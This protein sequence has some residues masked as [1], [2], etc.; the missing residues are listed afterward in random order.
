V[1]DHT[2]NSGT[3]TTTPDAEST[4]GA[5]SAITPYGGMS[6]KDVAHVLAFPPFNRICADLDSAKEESFRSFGKPVS[7]YGIL[8]T[9]ARL[10]VFRAGQFVVRRDDYG[11]SA[12]IVLEGEL[13]VVLNPLLPPAVLGRGESKLPKWGKLF[14]DALRNVLTPRSPDVQQLK[15][16]PMHSLQQGEG[17]SPLLLDTVRDESEYDT[18]TLGPGAIVGEMSAIYRTPRS[19]SVVADQECQVLEIRWQGL[20]DLMDGDTELAKEIDRLYRER[21]L[22]H[23]ISR[24]PIF[25]HIPPEATDQIMYSTFGKYD[26]WSADYLEQDA[27]ERAGIVEQEEVIAEQGHYANGV[28]VITGGFARQCK[29]LGAGQQTL[30]YLTSGHIFG[31]EEALHNWKNPSEAIALQTSLRA[32][33]YT[34]V[35]TVPTWIM[36]EHVFPHLD[37]D[38]L[39]GVAASGGLKGDSENP[40]ERLR[41]GIGEGLVEFLSENRFFNGTQ[42]MLIDLTRCTRCDDCV[43]GCAAAHDGNPRFVRHGPI[44]GNVQVA[45]ACMHCMDP[46][47]MIG[48]PT[49]AIYREPEQ[50]RVIIHPDTCIG[51]ST[52]SNNCPY[53]AIRM[54]ATRDG[55]GKF[56][57]AESGEKE[58]QPEYKATKCDLCINQAT[59][60]ACVRSCPHDALKRVNMHDADSLIRFVSS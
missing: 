29:R 43:R 17:M 37:A 59:G 36:E 12:F 7:V 6:D 48:C 31:L 52:C 56:V 51:C 4:H 13:R 45:N 1:T 19:S 39:P 34:H 50:G 5:S 26:E 41:E 3:R 54:V 60:P 55:E 27:Q 24:M 40:Q 16:P 44:S 32:A 25:Q 49:G 28:H 57:L 33:G 14:A 8:K 18:V 15:Q 9:H 53:N 21:S 22:V 47:C 2:E 38:A 23:T 46:V 58:G 20:R 30:S 10:R 35:F 42:T 11:T